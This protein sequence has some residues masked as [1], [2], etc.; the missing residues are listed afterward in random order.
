ME[1]KIKLTARQRQLRL[2]AIAETNGGRIQTSIF[3][4]TFI[5]CQK[6]MDENPCLGYGSNTASIYTIDEYDHLL[7]ESCQ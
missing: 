7:D 3:E 6:Y 2:C 4:G 5:E 1:K